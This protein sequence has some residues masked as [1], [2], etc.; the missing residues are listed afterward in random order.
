MLNTHKDKH[1]TLQPKSINDNPLLYCV[2]FFLLFDSMS[3]LPYRKGRNIISLFD[4]N[5]EKSKVFSING[6]ELQN[7]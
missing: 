5:R 7:E 6:R 4:H 2:G 1:E 3:I